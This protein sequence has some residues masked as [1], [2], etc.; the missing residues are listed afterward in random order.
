MTRKDFALITSSIRRSV[1]VTEF[2]EK[3]KERKNAKLSAYRLVASDLAGSIHGE[4][5]S[6]DMDRFLKDCGVEQ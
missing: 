6:F 3:N 4:N 2:T 1:Q 5:K